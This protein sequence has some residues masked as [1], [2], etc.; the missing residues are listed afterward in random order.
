MGP[1]KY[2]LA[3]GILFLAGRSAFSRWR[4]LSGIPLGRDMARV[5]AIVLVATMIT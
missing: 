3:R 5:F 1:Y 4:I 2:R